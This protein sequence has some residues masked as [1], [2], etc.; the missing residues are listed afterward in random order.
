MRDDTL[1][2]DEGLRSNTLLLDSGLVFLTALVQQV[3]LQWR[4]WPVAE[5]QGILSFL[6]SG[7]LSTSGADEPSAGAAS[8]AQPNGRAT[9]DSLGASGLLGTVDSAAADQQD[10][11]NHQ[12][13]QPAAA[14]LQCLGGSAAGLLPYPDGAAAQS[15][16]PISVVRFAVQRPVLRRASKIA[17]VIAQ[18]DFEVLSL[19]FFH[20]KMCHASTA[21]VTGLLPRVFVYFL[22][23]RQ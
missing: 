5:L 10:D 2:L 19:L 9:A 18:K 4:Q 17:G 8:Q 13:R 21:L 7:R 22:I 12:Q 11:Q 16:A 14:E 15:A 3:A 23:C 20:R 1:H 6:I